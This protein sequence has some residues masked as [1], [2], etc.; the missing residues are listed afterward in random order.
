MIRYL[1]LAVAAIMLLAACGKKEKTVK[2]EV[3][4]LTEAVYASGN[5]YPKNEYLVFANADGLLTRLLVQAGD[6]VSEGQPL[7]KIDSDIQDARLKSSNAIYHTAI[8]N[9]SSNSPALSEARTQVET[10]RIKMETDSVNY[11]RYKNLLENNATS[12]AEYDKMALAFQISKN[13]YQARKNNLERLRRQLFIELQNAESQ[14]NTSAKEGQNF[15]VKALLNGTV[16]EIYKERGEAVRRNDPIAL[17][18]DNKNIYLRLSVDELDIEKIKPGQEVLV[19]VDLYRDRVFKAK[20][21][22]IHRKMNVQDQSFRVDA[23]F[24]GEKPTAYYG[25][26]VEANIVIG[27]KENIL[28]IPKNILAAKD[29]VWVKTDDGI[30]KIKIQKGIEDFDFVEVTGGL[31]KESIVVNK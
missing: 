28:T 17:L 4:T 8:E 16:Y 22:R 10:A 3:K 23:E 20:I 19:K 21:T 5:I 31:S 27:R 24:I 18:G 30:Q 29:S 25:L 15:L 26:T 11:Y 14:Y 9:F 6:E 2:P 7:F 13:D 1:F 12:K